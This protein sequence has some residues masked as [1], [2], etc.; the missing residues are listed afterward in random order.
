MLAERSYHLGFVG[1]YTRDEAHV[2]GQAPG[3]YTIR[4]NTRTGEI[5]LGDHHEGLVNP[6][7]L[8]ATRDGRNLYV[9]EEADPGKVVAFGIEPDGQI[10]ELHRL[11]TGSSASC[12]VSLSPDE[13]LV[14]VC[15][16][17]GGRCELFR[18]STTGHLRASQ[19]FDLQA[20]SPPGRNSHA[21]F[22]LFS[23]DGRQ[24][25]VADLGLDRVWILS[26]D[27]AGKHYEYA[28]QR[29]VEIRNGSGPRHLVMNAS[30]SILYA[31]TEFSSEVVAFGRNPDDGHLAAM[32]HWSTLP[33][34]FG[35]V[36]F[37]ADIRMHPGGRWIL[38]SNRGHDSLTVFSVEKDG[39][40]RAVSHVAS[41]GE[42]P[43]AFAFSPD[44]HYLQVA[45]QNSNSIV[46]FRFDEATGAMNKIQDLAVPTPVCVDWAG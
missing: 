25:Y 1:T 18:R 12:H 8:A 9:V 38:A 41:G 13:S 27:A 7:F 11:P 6:S 26:L 43:R 29:W 28:A 4:A 17:V 37:C 22:T 35:R 19:S 32:G 34:A 39:T 30:S 16:Y 3:F 33:A 2:T 46:V 21:H 15:N 10:K 42:S 45:N 5:T 14:A 23:P 44:G 24:L 40:L 20:Q 36:N 31:V